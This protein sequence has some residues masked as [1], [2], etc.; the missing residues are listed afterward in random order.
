M[1]RRQLC[2]HLKAWTSSGSKTRQ[3]CSSNQ[4]SNITKKA[5]VIPMD[6]IWTNPDLPFKVAYT[7]VM[8]A[9]PDQVVSPHDS[10]LLLQYLPQIFNYQP[11][12]VT[13][14]RDEFKKFTSNKDTWTA[15][16]LER[17]EIYLTYQSD[18]FW[19]QRDPDS[20][21]LAVLTADAIIL[22]DDLAE[23]LMTSGDPGKEAMVRDFL[24]NC[25][26][27]LC[28][29]ADQ[30][31][32]RFES[33]YKDKYPTEYEEGKYLVDFNARLY[34]RYKAN[35]SPTKLAFISK[36]MFRSYNK[37]LYEYKFWKEALARNEH[38]TFETFVKT[39]SDSSFFALGSMVNYYDSDIEY[40]NLDHPMQILVTLIEQACNDLYSYPKEQAVGLNPFN[41][42]QRFIVVDKM[43][44][45]DALITHIHS[46]NE[47]M[48]ALE[49]SYSVLQGDAKIAAEAPLTIMTGWEK[50]SIKTR[51]YGWTE[52]CANTD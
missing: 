18:I 47:F 9:T 17:H 13:C 36:V 52:V 28:G 38:A 27:T 8:P 31:D 10:N 43:S 37:V 33:L 35:M 20:R 14:I 42:I 22:M 30:L 23:K 45:K 48:R 41:M 16:D 21:L 40:I 19:R 39:K 29:T 51:R 46:R 34:Q 44:L 2:S 26:D 3:V 12:N 24:F 6:S 32:Q 11:D 50:F 4:D 49:I 7:D 25:R 5:K 15:A 1:F